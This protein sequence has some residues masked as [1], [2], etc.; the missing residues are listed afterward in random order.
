M[1]SFAVSKKAQ[2]AQAQR[3]QRERGGCSFANHRLLYS[4]LALR[5]KRCLT[6]LLGNLF[7]ICWGHKEVFFRG[8]LQVAKV[9]GKPFVGLLPETV[10]FFGVVEVRLYFAFNLTPFSH[11]DEFIEPQ[12]IQPKS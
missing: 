4:C 6:G 7:I 11:C 2:E 12:M 9:A 5:K 1:C 8:I 3:Q 10:Q